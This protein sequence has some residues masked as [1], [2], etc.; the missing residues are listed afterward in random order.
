MAR[1]GQCCRSSVQDDNDDQIRGQPATRTMTDRSTRASSDSESDASRTQRQA[2]GGAPQARSGVERVNLRRKEGGASMVDRSSS[3]MPYSDETQPS[4]SQRLQ[5]MRNE[6]QGQFSGVSIGMTRAALDQRRRE[7]RALLHM[8]TMRIQHLKKHCKEIAADVNR[9]FD[10]LS[11]RLLQYKGDPNWLI[12]CFS[13]VFN[14][15]AAT[16]LEYEKEVKKLYK[17][18]AEHKHAVYKKIQV[19]KSGSSVSSLQKTPVVSVSVPEASSV[20]TVAGFP[21]HD[22][23]FRILDHKIQ[24]ADIESDSDDEEVIPLLDPRRNRPESSVSLLGQN[25][26]ISAERLPAETKISIQSAYGNQDKNCPSPSAYQLIRDNPVQPDSENTPQKNPQTMSRS[27]WKPREPPTFSGRLKEDVHQWTAIVN[28][29]FTLVPGTDQQHLTYAVSL[30]R[31]TAIEW[32]NTEVKKD[33][34]VDWKSLADA[35][36]LRF[37]STARSKRALLKIMQ[38]KQDKDDVL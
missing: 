9:Q 7:Q 26:G 18:V 2:V 22:N 25:Q 37:G 38:L 14:E 29:Y 27:E 12:E 5:Q 33:N 20:P 36:I 11:N 24:L 30:L 28:Q 31:G 35:L 1:K 6:C 10:E 23:P 13:V 16:V 32:Y 8:K 17:E 4:T 34:P 19:K 3:E 21:V 15:S